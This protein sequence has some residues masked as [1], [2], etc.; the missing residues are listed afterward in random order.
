M[1]NY[2]MDDI[3]NNTYTPAKFVARWKYIIYYVVGVFVVIVLFIAAI[4]LLDNYAVARHEQLFNEQQAMQTLLAKQAIEEDIAHLSVE[5]SIL[6]SFLLPQFS[7][8]EQDIDSLRNLFRLQQAAHPEIMAFIYMDRPDHIV[9]AQIADIAA[10]IEAERLSPAWVSAYWSELVSTDQGPL[11]PPFHITVDYQMYGLLFPVQVEGKLHGVLVIVIDMNPLI[12]R[13]V[14]PMRSGQYGAAYLLDNRGT[15]VYDHETEIIG[16]NVFDGMHADYPDVI[17][18]DQRLINEPSGQDEYHFTVQRGGQVS[19][20]LIAWH[21][22]YVG[23][24]KL[25]IALSAPDIEIDATLSDFR[26]QR[27][28]LGGLLALTLLAISF[29]FFRFRQH[30]SAEIARELKERVRRRTAELAA[31]EIRYRTLV[32]N[33]PLGIISFDREGKILSVN[34]TLLDILGSPSAEATM[35]INM[36]TFPPLVEAGLSASFIRCME[37]GQMIVA[38]HPYTSKWGKTT[39][40]RVHLAPIHNAAGEVTGGQALVEDVSALKQA[41]MTLR[42]S[43]QEFQTLLASITDYVWSADIVDGQVVYRYYSPVV[44]RITGYP[45]DHFMSGVDAWLNI[46]HPEDRPQTE[47]ML[48]QELQG[49]V[50]THEYRIIRPDGQVRWLSNTTSPTLDQAGKVVRLDG[51]V[52]DITKRKQA[53]EMRSTLEEQLYQA[54]KMEAI[55]NLAG[56]IAHDFNNMLTAIMGYTGLAME[57][58]PP[59][60]PVRSDIQGIQKTAQRAADLTR[61]LLAFARRQIIEPTI[62]NLNELIL[63][64]DKMLRRLIS[65]DIELVIL[66]APNLGR[67]KVDPSQ[68]EQILINLVINARDAMPHGG[69]LTIETAN[70]TVDQDDAQRHT[71]MPPGQ[72]VR[73]TVSDNGMGMTEEVKAHL[74]EPFFTTKEVNKGT[75]LG[76]ATCF[77]IIKQNEGHIQVHSNPDQ[78]TTFK[79]YLPCVPETGEPLFQPGEVDDLPRGTETILL[80]EDEVAVRD[81]ASRVLHQQGYT[82]FEAANGD[83]ALRLSEEQAGSEIDLLLTDMVMPRLG[84]A[85]LADRLKPIY[86]E[87]KILFIS[88]YIDNATIHDSV[89]KSGA[90]FLQK[91]FTPDVLARKVREVLDR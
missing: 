43:E 26:L 49:E 54:Q 48:A 35:A 80:V 90:A 12:T 75:G 19:R 66:L 44:E 71:G 16:R 38:E 28:M 17:R 32:E 88:G 67:V 56:G 31:S 27:I 84:G 63:N 11:V 78:G 65:E 39:H 60:H 91:P 46:I 21:T 2:D 22:A 24:Q 61:Q 33:A 37:S 76:L 73:L 55:G 57:A 47:R 81:L 7:Q 1:K 23:N 41:E 6:A 50:V 64:V 29:I 8:G 77:G 74:F 10:G 51:V 53:E 59:D 70:V 13:Y 68:I 34:P 40:L 15:I 86:P 79:I 4:F 3:T 42:Q 30:M 58:L 89:Q 62:L 82:V 20:K 25:V 87:L 36:L 72:Y 5:M 83:E 14:V 69:K 18:L 9:Y 52:S 45:P 85:A